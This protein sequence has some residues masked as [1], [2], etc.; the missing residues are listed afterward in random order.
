M[1]N[2]VGVDEDIRIYVENAVEQYQTVVY[3]SRSL[4]IHLRK[5]INS[6]QQ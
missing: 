3:I 2:V 6:M 5:L 1:L 4:F